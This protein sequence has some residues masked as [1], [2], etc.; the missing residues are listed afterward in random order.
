MTLFNTQQTHY[1]K[2]FSC[3]RTMLPLTVLPLIPL[4]SYNWGNR[5][6]YNRSTMEYFTVLL[7]HCVSLYIIIQ[8]RD[9]KKTPRYSIVHGPQLIMIDLIKLLI[10]PGYDHA[11][12]RSRM[13][14]KLC[15]FIPINIFLY[16]ARDAKESRLYRAG[17]YAHNAVTREFA[18]Y[19]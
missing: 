19:F 4:G 13:W 12:R 1:L 18:H 17:K 7:I 2:A 14:N 16:C 15:A 5:N 3:V 6:A 10:S 9:H 8:C 11:V